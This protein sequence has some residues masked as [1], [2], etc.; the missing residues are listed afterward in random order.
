MRMRFS[1]RHLI[2][3]TT[4]VGPICAFAWWRWTRSGP[5]EGMWTSPSLKVCLCEGESFFLFDDGKIYLYEENHPPANYYGSYE[6][7]PNDSYILNVLDDANDKV[8]LRPRAGTMTWY[9]VA[10][11]RSNHFRRLD[12]TPEVT[13]VVKTYEVDYTLVE[14]CRNGSNGNTAQQRTNTKSGPP[15]ESPGQL[16]N[17]PAVE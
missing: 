12:E 7:G 1:L 10:D 15:A 3:L 2:L 6:R 17:K 5:I 11:D 13:N 16:D 14:W 8:I 9:S 4:I